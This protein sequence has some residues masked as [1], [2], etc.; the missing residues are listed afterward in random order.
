MAPVFSNPLPPGSKVCVIGA[1]TTGLLAAKNARE[2]GYIPTIFEKTGSVGGV[3]RQDNP[4]P[5]QH[6]PAYDSLY[7]NSS[8]TMM[9]ISDFPF[10]F[11]TKYHFPTRSRT[12]EY[13]WTLYCVLFPFLICAGKRSVGIMRH[14]V[15]I[16]IFANAC[17]STLRPHSN[18]QPADNITSLALSGYSRGE[19]PFL[20]RVACHFPID[21]LARPTLTA[22]P[23]P[24]LN[25]TLTHNLN[26]NNI[27][28]TKP[29]IILLHRCL[30]SGAFRGGLGCEWAVL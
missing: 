22:T 9:N 23:T 3:W 17:A 20:N 12:A 11:K 24:T 13:N 2:Q 21:A 8:Y 25:A 16:T 26:V 27:G 14:I 18:D 15:S 4:G 19:S 1:G 28:I 5:K 30:F 10:P 6:S 29:H 7:T